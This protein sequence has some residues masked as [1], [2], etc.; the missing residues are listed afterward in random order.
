[1]ALNDDSILKFKTLTMKFEEKNIANPTV[2][3]GPISSGQSIP[4]TSHL[5]RSDDPDA[6]LLL[7]PLILVVAFRG[8][9]RYLIAQLNSSPPRLFFFFNKEGL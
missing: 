1:M 6:H 4:N 8:L 7:P 5:T 9:A 3:S 2:D